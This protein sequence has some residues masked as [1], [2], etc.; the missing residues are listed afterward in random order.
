MAVDG[1]RWGGT[2]FQAPA[3]V[4]GFPLAERCLGVQ[5]LVHAFEGSR[6]REIR[7]RGREEGG[8]REWYVKERRRG[9]WKYGWGMALME[10]LADPVL[11]EW[12]PAWVRE[13]YY[14]WNPDFQE[15]LV[16]VLREDAAYEMCNRQ[17]LFA[18]RRAMTVKFKKRRERRAKKVD[19]GVG[20]CC[21]S[22]G[23]SD[24]SGGSSEGGGAGDSDENCD[25]G[26]QVKKTWHKDAEPRPDDDLD[27]GVDAP[28]RWA[29]LSAEERLSAAPPAPAAKDGVQGAGAAGTGWLPLWWPLEPER[30]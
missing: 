20:G 27:E 8:A 22:S 18:T 15:S 13:Q 14:R 28:E 10:M 2:F 11:S 7:W 12:V 29:G 23:D 25:P 4:A 6:T 19:E 9:A 30:L 26:S 16:K 5:D 1:R 17:V 24:G 3:L 21:E